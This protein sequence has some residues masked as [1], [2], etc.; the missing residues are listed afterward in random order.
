FTWR[1]SIWPTSTG[2]RCSELSEI[3]GSAA[4]YLGDWIGVVAQGSGP[5]A[6]VAQASGSVAEIDPTGQ[7]LAS[8]VMPERLG[9][10]AHPGMRRYLGYLVGH[11]VR[12]PRRGTERV[13]GEH[14]CRGWELD[15]DVGNERLDVLLAL[16]EH[17]DR[18]R[19]DG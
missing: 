12:V 6:T 7:E 2:R 14:V 11:P 17:R 19:V 8:G 13:G 18:D 9:A 1:L 10:Q 4:V 5:A 16:G 3:G 15:A